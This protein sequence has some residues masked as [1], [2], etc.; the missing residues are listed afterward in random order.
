M[1]SMDHQTPHYEERFQTAVSSTLA[2]YLKNLSITSPLL[3]LWMLLA[4]GTIL[5]A[6]PLEMALFGLPHSRPLYRFVE[7]CDIARVKFFTS[8]QRQ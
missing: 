3:Y 6:D 8:Y 7:V 5:I 4:D 2:E 1:A